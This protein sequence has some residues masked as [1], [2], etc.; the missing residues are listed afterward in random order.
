MTDPMRVS[1]QW[2]GTTCNTY[3]YKPRENYIQYIDT[4]SFETMVADAGISDICGV[5]QLP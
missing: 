4:E 5:L 2:K 3:M 1:P